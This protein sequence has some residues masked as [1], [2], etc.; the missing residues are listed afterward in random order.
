MSAGEA[1]IASIAREPRLRF[2]GLWQT[3][4]WGFVALVVHLSLT[5]DP[6]DLGVPKAFDAGHVLAYFWL[7]FWFAQ[8]HHAG[9][10]RL[11]IAAGCL[12][13]GVA[14][15]FVQGMTGYRMFE[16]SDMALDALGVGIGL[17]LARTRLRYILGAVEG[18]IAKP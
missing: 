12:G 4:G 17:A 9:R 2:R 10:A 5:S 13:L 6:P 1:F 8:I 18:L 3:L 7:M 14:L 11:V 15:E 16:Y